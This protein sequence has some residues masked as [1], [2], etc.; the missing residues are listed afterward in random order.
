MAPAAV[1]VSL[2]GFT[3]VGDTGF[4]RHY[5]DPGRSAEDD[6]KEVTGL[7]DAAVL[8]VKDIDRIPLADNA[9]FTR[10]LQG[11]NPHRVAWIVPGHPAVS[12]QGE[13]LDRW[14]QPLFFHRESSRRTALR[15][16]GPDREMWTGDDIVFPS[17]EGGGD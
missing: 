2:E 11:E 3:V 14:E 10:F 1:A 7:L 5:R 8:L 12:S 17:P 9:D 13:L 16:A 6:L 4:A 15:S